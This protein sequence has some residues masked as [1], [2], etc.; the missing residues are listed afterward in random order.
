[1]NLSVSNNQFY[2]IQIS[3][4]TL[5]IRLNFYAKSK[6]VQLRSCTFKLSAYLYDSNHIFIDA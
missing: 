3:K 2:L 5:I 6:I 1:M 4:T